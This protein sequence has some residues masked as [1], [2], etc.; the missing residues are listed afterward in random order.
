MCCFYHSTKFRF[1]SLFSIWAE[2][3]GGSKHTIWNNIYRPFNSKQVMIWVFNILKGNTITIWCSKITILIFCPYRATVVVSVNH[4]NSLSLIFRQSV[5]CVWTANHTSALNYLS[6]WLR[7]LW[8]HKH[9]LHY[10]HLFSRPSTYTFFFL[11][12]SWA[13][14]L[15][16][17]FLLTLFRVLSSAWNTHTEI[18]QPPGSKKVCSHTIKSSQGCFSISTWTH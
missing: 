14:C 7:P 9:P 2:W 11:R 17:I 3:M 13:D 6:R 16:R 12:L 5:K 10:P 18:L 1:N 4:S 8:H 15:F